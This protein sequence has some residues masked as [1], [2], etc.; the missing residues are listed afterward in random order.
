M[1]RFDKSLFFGI[2]VLV[3]SGPAISNAQA[4]E[5]W[6][7]HHPRRAEVLGR[8]HHLDHRIH[9]E[10]IEGELSP[11]RAAALHQQVRQVVGTQNWEA[12]HQGGIL[13]GYITEGQ[14]HQLNL[15]ENAISQEVGQ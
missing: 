2:F 7:R 14:Q 8:A 12:R 1:F 6:T 15:R 13:N 11:A 4:G 10:V 5:V 9:Q 3:L